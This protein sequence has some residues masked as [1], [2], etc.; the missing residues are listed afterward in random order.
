MTFGE[1]LRE[2]HDESIRLQ[3]EFLVVVVEIRALA[4]KKEA[5]TE[6]LI[7]KRDTLYNQFNK[8]LKTHRRLHNYVTEHAVD[9]S[10]GY[11]EPEAP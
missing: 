8:I 4:T 9:L 2:L 11:H 3:K 7:F 6:E 10:K 5:L 1:K